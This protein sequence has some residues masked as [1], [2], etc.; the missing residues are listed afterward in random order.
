MSDRREQVAANLARVR[1]R[2]DAAAQAAGRDSD[3]VTLI[4]VTKTFPAADVELLA[5]L[6]VTDIGENRHPEAEQ[7]AATVSADLTWHFVGGLQTNKARA[8]ARYADVVHSVDRERLVDALSDGATK[9]D[10]V[11]DCLVQVS[12]DAAAGDNR[13][14]APPELVPELANLVASADGLRLRGVM[15]VAPLE[16][17]AAVAFARLRQVSASVR[18]AHPGAD[19]ISAGMSGDLEAAI[20]AGATHARIGRAVLGERPP[21]G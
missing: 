2:I 11:V 10:R 6:G 16:G 13:S 20:A 4:V 7:K 21:L 17:D 12:L 19:V 18:A 15:A 1:H 5:E 9:A 8:V 3:S 14:G